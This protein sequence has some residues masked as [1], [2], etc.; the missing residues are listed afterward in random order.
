MSFTT[1]A[2]ENP[3]AS[4]GLGLGIVHSPYASSPASTTTAARINGLDLFI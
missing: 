1:R 2:D 3:S 4:A